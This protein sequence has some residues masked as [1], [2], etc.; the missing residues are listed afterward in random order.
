MLFVFR[1][2]RV[3]VSAIAL[4]GVLSGALL[5]P[6]NAWAKHKPEPAPPP[7][8]HASLPAL[9]TVPVDALGFAPPGDIYLGS[10]NTLVSL[11]FLDEDR[12]LFTFRVP[13]LLRRDPSGAADETDRYI[14]ALVLHIPD[15]HVQAEAL[16]TL[17]DR[18]RYLYPLDNGQ[19][20]LRDRNMLST[21]DGT[22]QPTPWLRFPGPILWVEMDPTHKFLVTG[23]REPA[24]ANPA[25]DDASSSATAQASAAT[26]NLDGMNPNLG[27]KQQDYVLR[28]LQRPSAQVLLLTHVHNAI[29]LPLSTEGYLDTLRSTHGDEWIVN[30]DYITGGTTRVGAIDS[31]C[32]PTLDF[33]SPREYLARVCDESGARII[34][35]FTL[36]GKELWSAKGRDTNVWP[37]L[38]TNQNGTRLAMEVLHANH[39]I[40]ANATSFTTE[41]ITSQEVDVFDAANGHIALRAQASPIFDAGGNVAI[42]PTGRRAAILM[43]DGIEVFNLPDPPAIPAK[44]P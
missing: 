22:L 1:A 28:I 9:C 6:C 44:Q 23:S 39:S 36:E 2:T 11:D 24:A 33:L 10:H 12:L 32:V 17:H 27:V 30:L 38:T 3:Q 34:E 14:R 29:H 41:D 8:P 7:Q 31:A 42:S 35:A 43:Q 13:G 37:V 15:G 40:N 26:K 25:A 16:W 19:F 18:A 20:L 21:G 5:L 4:L